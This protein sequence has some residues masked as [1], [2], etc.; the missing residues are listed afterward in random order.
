MSDFNKV[1]AI[2]VSEE[3]RDKVFDIM[4]LYEMNSISDVVRML[5]DNYDKNDDA[6]ELQR[7]K[8]VLRNLL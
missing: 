7:I 2:R 5:I 4:K 6:M 8:A 1:L 3:Q